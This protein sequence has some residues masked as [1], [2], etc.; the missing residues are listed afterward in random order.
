MLHGVAID[1]AAKAQ[2]DDEQYA[3]KEAFHARNS[4]TRPYSIRWGDYRDRGQVPKLEDSLRT[5]SPGSASPAP[6]DSR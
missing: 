2:D 4:T 3:Q 5:S 1:K 6:F